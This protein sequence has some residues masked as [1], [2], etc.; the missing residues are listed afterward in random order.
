[1]AAGEDTTAAVRRELKAQG[2]DLGEELGAFWGDKT[3][4]KPR[5]GPQTRGKPYT[6]GT[7]IKSQAAGDLL[8][9]RD[10]DRRVVRVSLE[11]LEDA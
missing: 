4:D 10:R 7:L 8:A 3:L 6:F 9:L 1:M 2:K 5:F 11:Q